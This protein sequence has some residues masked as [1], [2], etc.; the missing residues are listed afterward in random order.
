MWQQAFQGFFFYSFS[1]LSLYRL[2]TH[3][4]AEILNLC[5]SYMQWEFLNQDIWAVTQSATKIGNAPASYLKKKQK[6]NVFMCHMSRHS[7][8]LLRID[9]SGSVVAPVTLCFTLIY[10][11]PKKVKKLCFHQL[12]CSRLWRWQQETL[13]QGATE[14]RTTVCHFWWNSCTD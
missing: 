9:G 2:Q 11:K 13:A 6:K 10:V 14:A 12:C 4:S 7:H 3:I 5:Y 1:F 8:L